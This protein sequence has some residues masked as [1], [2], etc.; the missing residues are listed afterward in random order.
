MK[1]LLLIGLLAV[2]FFTV[3]FSASA[4]EAKIFHM[5]I[6]GVPHVAVTGSD[7]RVQDV[8]EVSREYHTVAKE[9]VRKVAKKSES[10]KN[11]NTAIKKDVPAN[12]TAGLNTAKKVSENPTMSGKNSAHQNSITPKDTSIIPIN[13]AP[14][15]SSAPY[16]TG[17]VKNTESV[18][19]TAKNS[20]AENN[21]IGRKDQILVESSEKDYPAADGNGHWTVSR[22]KYITQEKNLGGKPV[23]RER[24]VNKTAWTNL[25]KGGEVKKGFAWAPGQIKPPE[26]MTDIGGKLNGIDPET[27]Q[28][29]EMEIP[30]GYAVNYDSRGNSASVVG[31][32]SKVPEDRHLLEKNIE[33]KGGKSRV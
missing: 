30:L 7:G 8:F 18:I 1:R 27:G 17:A 23:I 5:E 20:T 14:K 32:F 22:K 19:N 13:T 10:P 16:G 11:I 29:C 9:K 15:C 26:W 21:T 6:G 31:K 28:I 33:S 12:N 24:V 2:A 25:N 4:S 3:I